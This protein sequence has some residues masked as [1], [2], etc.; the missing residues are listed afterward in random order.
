LILLQ[1]TPVIFPYFYNYL[2]AGSN[3]VKGYYADPQGTV[4]LSHTSLG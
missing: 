2:T 1:D 4:Y 3:S